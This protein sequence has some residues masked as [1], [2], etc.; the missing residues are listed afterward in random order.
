MRR[1]IDRRTFL[2]LGGAATGVIGGGVAAKI[3]ADEDALLLGMWR[4]LL[5]IPRPI[6]QSQVHGS[7]ADAV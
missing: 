5:P 1:K 4:Y 7:T 3:A 6:W 2:K